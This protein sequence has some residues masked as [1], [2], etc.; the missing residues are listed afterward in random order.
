MLVSLTVGRTVT[1]HTGSLGAPVHGEG[2]PLLL[3]VGHTGSVTS[4]ALSPDEAELASSSR[5]GTVRLFD[6]STGR[7]RDEI[8]LGGEVFSVA[9]SPDGAR[10]ATGSTYNLVKLWD[11]RTTEHL[12]TFQDNRTWVTSV[13][14]TPDGR[15]LASCDTEGG[16]VIRDL[17]QGTVSKLPILEARGV[18][19][20]PDGRT[21]AVVAGGTF[22]LFDAR[23]WEQSP[24]GGARTAPVP[25]AS[26]AVGRFA[27]LTWNATGGELAFGET[28]VRVADLRG[29][30]ERVVSTEAPSALAF[31]PDRK[32]LAIGRR[33][34]GGITIVD[35]ELG[36]TTARLPAS[37]STITSLCWSRDGARLFAG[38]EHGG[39]SIWSIVKGERL[40]DLPAQA[41]GVGKVAWGPHDRL[42]TPNALWDLRR[43]TI[44]TPLAPGTWSVSWCGDVLVTLEE[45][46][47][48][49]RQG[50]TGAVLGTAPTLTRSTQVICAPDGARA[51]VY[52]YG[53]ETWDTRA[54]TGL[55][56]AD[57]WVSSTAWGPGNRV[58]LGLEHAIEIWRFGKGNPVREIRRRGGARR[59]AW[60]LDGLIAADIG[61]R[62]RFNR[63]VMEAG[64]SVL[65]GST[66]APTGRWLDSC[67]V[68]TIDHCDWGTLAWNPD[69]TRLAS[70][71]DGL[72][73]LIDTPLGPGR[74]VKLPLQPHPGS[75]DV[76]WS[77]DGRALA[78][79]DSMGVLLIR[80]S[81]GATVRLRDVRV[82]DQLLGLVDD[83]QGRFCGDDEVSAKVVK[84]RSSGVPATMSPQ[85]ASEPDLLER[86]LH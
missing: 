58:V 56:V 4:L 54:R 27:A 8:R 20:G 63:Y 74:R 85:P 38:D 52:G 64:L 36:K 12:A 70:I 34:G 19:W 49:W 47:I 11:A 28:D 57:E 55:K 68:G 53:A 14:F 3:N 46:G 21:L 17:T 31:S 41:P 84:L 24:D 79:A 50:E 10:L 86:F 18:A 37:K 80:L 2:Q 71:V 62:R 66:L 61:A 42:A 43:G 82:G 78:A 67:F 13:A 30:G 83:E 39:I 15:F 77:P 25:S 33:G 45:K 40:V 35:M 75:Y 81:D 69:G 44:V 1:A 29:R 72:L 16:V 32:R 5:D 6:A 48:T 60:R 73:E 7:L 65:R 59:L 51:L 26:K 23:A 76:A 9:F 22:L